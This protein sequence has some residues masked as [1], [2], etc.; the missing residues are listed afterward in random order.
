MKGEGS[1]KAG[2]IV[3]DK[4]IKELVGYAKEIWALL[5]S[6]GKPLKALSENMAF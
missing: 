5:S 3:R 2:N 4:V 6:D 1:S